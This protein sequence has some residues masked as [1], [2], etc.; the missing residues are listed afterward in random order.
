MPV[1]LQ[2]RPPLIRKPSSFS[3]IT[4]VALSES[5]RVLPETFVLG[6]I[7]GSGIRFLF[8][9]G[10]F[11][12][13]FFSSRLHYRIPVVLPHSQNPLTITLFFTVVKRRSSV[14][15][16]SFSS[17]RNQIL[18]LLLDDIPIPVI[19]SS[20]FPTV[21]YSI[22]SSTLDAFHHLPRFIPTWREGLSCCLRKT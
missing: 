1:H 6:F 15:S 3:I 18:L 14:P 7:A 20:H 17:A 19:K 21:G 2:H 4:S 11:P 9:F 12:R 22:P 10:F 13:N 5:S 16:A 8:F